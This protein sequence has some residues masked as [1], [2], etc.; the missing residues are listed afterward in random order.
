MLNSTLNFNMLLVFN[1]LECMINIAKSLNIL[2][3]P[4]SK[5]YK[6]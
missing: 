4:I 3:L 2:T 6:E 5:L 1:N